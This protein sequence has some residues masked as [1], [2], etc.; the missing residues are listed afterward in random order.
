M[1][2]SSAPSSTRDVAQ[3]NDCPVAVGDDQIL[4]F[5][6]RSEVGVGE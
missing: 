4:E 6:Y 3:A 1:L 5:V 2:A